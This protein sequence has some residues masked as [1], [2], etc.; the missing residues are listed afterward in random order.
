MLG[1]PTDIDN[2]ATL[3]L[4][5]K[6]MTLSV[7][8]QCFQC[9]VMS[10]LLY[11]G[12]T[13]PVVPKTHQPFGCLPDELLATRLSHFFAG[14]CAKFDIL[15]RCNTF[16]VE[17]QLQSKRLRWLGYMFRMPDKGLPKKLFVKSRVA[18][19]QIALGLV[20]MMLQCVIVNFI[21]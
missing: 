17:S 3:D 12:K 18:G 4:P 8:M 15:T 9:I 1:S 10:L 21:A 14:P 16:P 2:F 7:K 19:P 5:S 13:W 6:T 20:S 11:S